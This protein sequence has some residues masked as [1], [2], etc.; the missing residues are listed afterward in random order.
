LKD[1]GT[2]QGIMPQAGM[3][4]NAMKG[5]SFFDYMF[6]ANA[7]APIRN[8]A[9]AVTFRPFIAQNP[10]TTQHA[11]MMGI[12]GSAPLP[13]SEA[14]QKTWTVRSSPYSLPPSRGIGVYE[15]MLENTDVVNPGEGTAS[16]YPKA[17]P[18]AMKP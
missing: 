15:R 8:F 13:G 12:K 3:G 9:N 2:Q 1:C 7:T 14:W 18:V 10:S 6:P 5:G 11:T 4:S 17:T 16:L